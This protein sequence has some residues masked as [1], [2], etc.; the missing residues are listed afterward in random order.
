MAEIEK[1]IH[2]ITRTV[3]M[4]GSKNFS[5]SSLFFKR[6]QKRR[7]TVLYAFVR[8][9]DN[10][11]DTTPPDT[12][13]L[14]EF[15][16]QY[17]VRLS[18]GECP[19]NAHTPLIEAF[20][21]LQHSCAFEQTWI[22]AFL[23]SMHW[24]LSKTEYNDTREIGEYM[25][26]SAE[27]VGLCMTRILGIDVAADGYACLFGRALQYIN[28]IRDIDEDNRFGRRYLPLGNGLRDLQRQTAE[29]H[30]DEFSAYL[31]EQIAQFRAWLRE[32]M[33]GLRYIPRSARVPIKTAADV[34]VII[35]NRIDH[36]PLVVYRRKV[37]VSRLR[38][39]FCVV[40]NVISGGMTRER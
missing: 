25:H 13:Q 31:R 16:T 26:G 17:R 11:V 36:D 5:T 1:D 32:G 10:F 9:I 12:V 33:R 22:D 34:F 19:R 7:V 27:I 14:N 4:R 15:E 24:D 28:F 40:K 35:A 2:Q 29:Q 18:G 21:A 3:F 37:G 39:V 30:T 8:T 23:K 20:L 6:A 38:I